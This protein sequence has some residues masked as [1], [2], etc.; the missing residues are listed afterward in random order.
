MLSK[1][2]LNMSIFHS[3]KVEKLKVPWGQRKL[4]SDDPGNVHRKSVP[5]KQ[6]PNKI[7]KYS[8]NCIEFFET[9]DEFKQFSMSHIKPA[10]LMYPQGPKL[11][12]PL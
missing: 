8:E 10:H 4:S 9:G 7:N 6:L 5:I 3:F 1:A 12:Y 11:Q 2:K